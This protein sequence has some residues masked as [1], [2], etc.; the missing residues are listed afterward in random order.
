MKGKTKAARHHYNL[1]LQKDYS[2]RLLLFCLQLQSFVS[3]RITASCYK[4]QLLHQY[5]ICFTAVKVYQ[6]RCRLQSEVYTDVLKNH[7]SREFYELKTALE[8]GVSK[9]IS[10]RYTEAFITF[11]AE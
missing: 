6:L 4:L 11:V 8:D 5:L 3:T 9:C 7:A 2:T 1:P 10:Q